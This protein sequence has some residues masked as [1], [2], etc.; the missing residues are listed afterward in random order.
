VTHNLEPCTCGHVYRIHGG[1]PGWDLP[2]GRC[3][4]TACPC[5]AFEPA[6]LTR[7]ATTTRTAELDDRKPR[8]TPRAPGRP[9]APPRAPTALPP[10]HRPTSTR[11]PPRRPAGS[12]PTTTRPQS[13]PHPQPT[14]RAANDHHD[15]D[16]HLANPDT[17]ATASHQTRHKA[18]D[19]VTKGR[20]IAPGPTRHDQMPRPSGPGF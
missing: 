7:P 1:R 14:E 3:R 17:H 2:D 6:P 15:A 12:T 11:P 20:H 9:P 8:G 16:H 19:E 10:A 4:V 13:C 18:P 5:P